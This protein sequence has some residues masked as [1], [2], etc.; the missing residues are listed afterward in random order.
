MADFFRDNRLGISLFV[1]LRNNLGVPLDPSAA[2][3]ANEQIARQPWRDD[4]CLVCGTCSETGFRCQ[5]LCPEYTSTT[6]MFTP[7]LHM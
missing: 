6:Y 5:G 2:R 3:V 4:P 7:L 1:S